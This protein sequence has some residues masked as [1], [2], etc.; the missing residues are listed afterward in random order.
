MTPACSPRGEA[1]RP[2]IW[3]Q[4]NMIKNGLIKLKKEYLTA[5]EDHMVHTPL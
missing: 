2:A 1:G 3:I 5:A 4:E